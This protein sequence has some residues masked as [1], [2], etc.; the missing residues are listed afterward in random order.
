MQGNGDISSQFR[1]YC[2][3]ARQGKQRGYRQVGKVLVWHVIEEQSPTP[4]LI[5]FLDLLKQ[6]DDRAVLSWLRKRYPS[7][8]ALV[9]RECYPQLLRGVY[10][11]AERLELYVLPRRLDQEADVRDIDVTRP[12]AGRPLFAWLRPSTN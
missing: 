6:R 4:E 8:L 11:C 9:P 10:T 1:L 12:A 3:S 5:D 7:Y 2:E